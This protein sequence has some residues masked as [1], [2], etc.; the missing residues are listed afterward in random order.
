MLNPL[1]SS[2]R[3]RDLFPTFKNIAHDL[4]DL[5]DRHIR[6]GEEEIDM[7]KYLS[8]AGLAFIADAGLGHSFGGLEES[9]EF[10]DAVK[11]MA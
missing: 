5:L 2:N 8:R 9:N 10:E 7:S 6:Q 4:C 3:M 1:F 11:M